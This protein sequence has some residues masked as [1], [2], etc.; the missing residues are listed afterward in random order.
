MQG[1]EAARRTKFFYPE[2]LSG[3]VSIMGPM[4]RTLEDV[5]IDDLVEFVEMVYHGS[6]VPG[7]TDDSEGEE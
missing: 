2:N 1:Y 3:V 5:P 4:G 7:T 6:E